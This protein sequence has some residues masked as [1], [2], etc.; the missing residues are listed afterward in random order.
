M[1]IPYTALFRLG[2]TD[3]PINRRR[4]YTTQAYQLKQYL[5]VIK[6]AEFHCFFEEL[7]LRVSFSTVVPVNT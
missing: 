2:L 6:F 5:Q 7:K 3:W 1:S 4:S